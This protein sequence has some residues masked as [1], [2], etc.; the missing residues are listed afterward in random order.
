M[1]LFTS[2]ALSFSSSEAISLLSL[3]LM[4]EASYGNQADIIKLDRFWRQYH[5]F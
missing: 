3:G 1:K 4:P 2:I 5:A